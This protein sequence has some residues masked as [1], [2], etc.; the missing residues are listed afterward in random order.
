MDFK[1]DYKRILTIQDISCFGQCSLTVA[2]PILSA[3]G[4][5]TVILPSAVLSTHT[6]GFSGF[7][8]RDLTDD[9]P[10]IT[11]HWKKEGIDFDAIYTGYLGSLRQ[12]D[13]VCEIFNTLTRENGIKIVDPAMADNGKLYY[14]FTEEYA[15]AMARLCAKADIVIPNI[16]EA[17]FMTGLEYKEK[18][19]EAYVSEV[20]SALEAKGMS[21]IVLTGVTYNEETT[22]VVVKVNGK[23]EYY[24][25]YRFPVGSHGTGDIFA[26]AFSGALL[27]GNSEYDS[28]RIAANYTLRCIENTQGDESHRYGVKFE[29]AIPYLLKELGAE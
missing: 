16:T 10:K 29:T 23:T 5:E 18:Y 28:A 20:L 3:C 12:I 27:R 25:H 22:G 2:L 7:N 24:K 19:D 17:C 1:R 9:I 26:S 4:V 21:N 14:G 15:S 13:M 11:A 8:V 6:G